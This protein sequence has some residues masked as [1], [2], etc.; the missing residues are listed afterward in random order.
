LSANLAQF[1]PLEVEILNLLW[2]TDVDFS[3]KGTI[4]QQIFDE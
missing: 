4:S 2:D 3:F 1:S